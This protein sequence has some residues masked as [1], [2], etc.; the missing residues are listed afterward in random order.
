VPVNGLSS[1][2][3]LRALIQPTFAQNAVTFSLVQAPSLSRFRGPGSVTSVAGGSTV[4]TAPKGVMSNFQGV[5]VGPNDSFV[6]RACLISDPGECATGTITLRLD[7]SQSFATIENLARGTCAGGCHENA[8]TGANLRM[9][10][11]VAE[12]SS[13]ALYCAIRNGSSA[14]GG[15]GTEAANT[16]YV[17]LSSSDS[18]VSLFYRKPS[19]LD[20]HGGGGPLGTAAQRQAIATWIA[21]G[22]YFT[23]GSVQT[24]P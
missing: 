1:T 21:E 3:N 7:G 11:T 12:Q 9:F 6:Y 20:G 8:Q 22:A 23:S 18:T 16:P 24:C 4:Y 13:K 15:S 17:N 5:T 14:T 2:I 10:P 19:G